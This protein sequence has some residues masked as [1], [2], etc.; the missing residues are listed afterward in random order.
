MEW[1]FISDNCD[2]ISL[3]DC[4]ISEFVFGEDVVL[5]F[6]DGFD[7][8][9]QNLL[10]ETGRHKRTGKAA[11][12]LKN[13]RYISGEMSLGR[14]YNS[15]GEGFTD[16]CRSIEKN[17]LSELELEVLDFKFED[18][19][20]F[21]VGD[22]WKEHSFCELKFSCEKVIFCWNEFTDDAWFQEK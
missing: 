6:E 19:T 7:V 11:A 12:V 5:I 17:E 9:A 3:H 16:E 8:A 1:K 10:N 13:G 22:S 14:V 15:A 4:D 21:F 20:A 2:S 18:G